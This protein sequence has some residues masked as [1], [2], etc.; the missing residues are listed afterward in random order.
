MFC[1]YL[2]RVSIQAPEPE[3]DPAESTP[4]S[5]FNTDFN[6]DLNTDL[7]TD[8]NTAFAKAQ[9]RYAPRPMPRG[10]FL[11][12]LGPIAVTLLAALLRLPR[13]GSPHAVVFDETYYVKD[14]LSLLSFGVEHK[15]VDGADA[16][17]LKSN[18]QITTGLFTNDPSYIV[19]PPIGKWI[20]ASGEHFFG[21]TPFGWRI[22]IALCGILTVLLTAR[23]ARRIARSNFVGTLAGAFLAIDGL[24]IV[25]SRT[26]L[27]D[28]P[29]SLFVL[30]AFGCLVL[31]RDSTR[32]NFVRDAE[33]DQTADFVA[34]QSG[35][36]KWRWFMVIFLGLACGTKWS[37][38][39]FAVTFGLMMLWWD[40]ETR[41][42]THP[43]NHV[44]TWFK[45]DL[46]P[47]LT[48]PFAIIAIY[49]ASWVGWFRSTTGWF[50]YWAQDNDAHSWLPQSLVS[51]M[52]Y[53]HDMLTFHTHL[54]SPHSYAANPWGWPLMIR[55]TSFFYES[56]ATCHAASCAQEVLP[57]GN[58]VVWWGGA[59]A[60]IALFIIA[61]R[62]HTE[63][64]APIVLAFASG[65]VPWLFFAHR[66]VFTFYSVV[67]IPY[68]VMALAIGLC[69]LNKKLVKSK[70]PVRL[71]WPA[72][73]TL[74][75]AVVLAYF[76][77][78]LYVA[79]SLPYDIWHARMWFP[80][81]I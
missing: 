81:W 30:A 34:P 54:T 51:L 67:F 14:A 70:L 8:F 68:T 5:D 77:F 71:R 80:S 61:I 48:M 55:P 66:T 33:F 32:K 63:Y 13:L 38:L 3:T 49:L 72:L 7:N 78:P 74:T 75:A 29:L 43:H 15:T 41:A 25:M 64:A 60:I 36:Y 59:I 23:I 79:Q 53:H 37:G 35:S 44:T 22:G 46:L 10:G 52:H 24:H 19:H 45:R 12:W 2:G 50:R 39:Y 4:N 20:I 16:L 1:L 11:G 6:T 57:L 31:D 28:T 62:R 40:A 27:L 17:L 56:A 58:P 65:W 18:G 47:A 9:D 69:L 76:F 42:V 21:A 26:A 73:V